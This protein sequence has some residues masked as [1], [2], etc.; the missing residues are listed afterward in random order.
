M[1]TLVSGSSGLVGTALVDALS[2]DG[3]SVCRLVRPQSGRKPE[4]GRNV[5]WDPASGEFDA[6][7]AEGANAVV[8]LAGA[9]IAAGRWNNERKR[10]LRSSRVDATRHLVSALSKLVRPPQAFISASAIG[11]YGDR[12]DEELLE[13]SAPGSD[14]LATLARDWEAEAARAEKLDARVVMLRF[15]L[16]LA[17]HGGALPRML[18]PF[19]LGLGGRLGSGQ[20]W[21]SWLTLSEAIGVI[22]YALENSELRGAVNAVTPNPVRN[23]EFTAVLGG[24]LHRP[25]IFPAPPFALRLA[26]GE[27]ADSLLLASQRVLPANLQAHGYSFRQPELQPALAAILK[28]RS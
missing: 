5:L 6:A 15:G 24:V 11:Y 27:M 2:R 14:F 9:S 12:S 10:V 16:I 21:M 26:L 23:R 28:G 4:A 18:A 20:Q 13:D 8:H 3:H 17:R 19:R 22:R 25:T 7:T 1:K